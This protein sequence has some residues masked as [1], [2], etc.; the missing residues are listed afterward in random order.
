M[1]A[2]KLCF[3]LISLLSLSCTSLSRSAWAQSRGKNI[4][5]DPILAANSEAFKVKLNTKG[6]MKYWCLQFGDFRIIT[7]EM[8]DL[9]TRESSNFL[10][11]K[12]THKSKDHISF[13]LHSNSP[14]SVHTVAISEKT[15]QELRSLEICR[16]FYW[17]RD[18]F[19]KDSHFLSAIIRGSWDKN[20][21]WF[22][23]IEQDYGKTRQKYEAFLGN[24]ERIIKIIH[25][26]S[27]SI[28]KNKRIYPALGYELIEDKEALSAV[29]YHGGGALG[30]FKKTIWIKSSIDHRTK[31][32]L[33]AAMSALILL[34]TPDYI[35][36]DN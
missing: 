23:L 15:V 12:M 4:P 18:D 10:K 36:E 11:T 31:L 28:G 16:D 8:G 34:E 21:R 3:L 27:N 5:I 25:L 6:P 19:L 9:E 35:E 32:I 2:F 22:L 30:L 14:D 24:D 13:S 26:C 17:G 33:A 7:H 1:K 20:T 29:Q